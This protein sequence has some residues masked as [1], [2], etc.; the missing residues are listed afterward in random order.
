MRWWLQCALPE[1]W[2][3]PSVCKESSK[4]LQR[5][6]IS[7]LPL[8]S[9]RQRSHWKICS[10]PWVD[11]AESHC[12][13]CINAERARTSEHHQQKGSSCREG[14]C[15]CGQ[16]H[17][18]AA[19]WLCASSGLLECFRMARMNSSHF[20]ARVERVARSVILLEGFDEKCELSWKGRR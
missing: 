13:V 15:A 2:G 7:F 10:G 1:A 17:S 6:A 8:S 11:E 18:Q 4:K 20:V 9:L 16:R 3:P 19:A 5:K 14:R 12:A